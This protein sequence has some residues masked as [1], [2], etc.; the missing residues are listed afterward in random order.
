MP[1]LVEVACTLLYFKPSVVASTYIETMHTAPPAR[2][3]LDKLAEAAPATAVA[4]PLQV[5]VNPFGVA[6]NSPAGRLS[7][8]ATPVSDENVF[9]LVRVKVS[10]V[11]L[12]SG[13]VPSPKAF[14]I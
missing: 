6:A 7:V 5:F 10:D 12:S 9:G 1:P 3:A 4:V 11:M 2:V 8:K 14:V 13:I